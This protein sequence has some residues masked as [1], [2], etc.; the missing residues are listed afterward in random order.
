MK[1]QRKWVE[2]KHGAGY[3]S[4][5]CATETITSIKTKFTCFFKA[6]DITK[7]ICPF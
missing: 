1:I 2:N 3:D 4:R 5:T 7:H 6:Q